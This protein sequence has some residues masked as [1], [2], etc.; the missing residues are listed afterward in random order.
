M[1]SIRQ[2]GNRLKVANTKLPKPLLLHSGTGLRNLR[3]RYAL[4]VDIIDGEH[5]FVVYL[6]LLEK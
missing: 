1:L 6:N 3:E 2:E 5:E 4:L